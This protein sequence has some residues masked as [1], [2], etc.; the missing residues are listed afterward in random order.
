MQL[1][2]PPTFAAA[3]QVAGSVFD[4]GAAAKFNRDMLLVGEDATELHT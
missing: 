2:V 1:E 4:P 3:F